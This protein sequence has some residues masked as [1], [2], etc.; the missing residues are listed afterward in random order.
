MLDWARSRQIG[1]SHFVSLGDSADVDLADVLDYLGR[2]SGDAGDRCL[3]WK[4]S[5]PAAS[6]CAAARRCRATSP[7]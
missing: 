1:F 2:R 5:G 7:C 3:M 4:R 6:S